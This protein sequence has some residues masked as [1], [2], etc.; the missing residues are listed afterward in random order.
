MTKEQPNG[1]YFKDV[2]NDKGYRWPFRK[3]GARLFSQV[4]FPEEMTFSEIGRMTVLSK[5]MV[6]NT[7]MLGYR[8]N[9]TILP[10]T[11]DELYEIIQL[12]RSHGSE[13][14]SKMIRLHILHRG[15]DTLGTIQYYVNPAYFMA[16]GQ[17]LSLDLY[18]KFQE[19]LQPLL[20]DWV[21]DGF[22]DQASEKQVARGNQAL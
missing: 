11:A 16:V 22:L 5:E 20:P 2:F 12:S 10:Y 8:Q 15:F 13:F 6:G 7:N 4:K 3:S 14:L 19:D 17:R 21:I 18:L 9:R 1:D